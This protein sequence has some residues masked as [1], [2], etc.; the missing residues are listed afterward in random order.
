MR[1]R[2]DI[3]KKNRVDG[4]KAPSFAVKQVAV[5]TP[6]ALRKQLGASK[7]P[8]PVLLIFAPGEMLYGDLLHFIRPVRKTHPTV[9]VFPELNE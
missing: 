8:L 9:Y 7:N 3:V 6:A 2:F 1:G 4:Q 5:S